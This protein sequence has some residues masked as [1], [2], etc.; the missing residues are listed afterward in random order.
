MQ[1]KFLE[2]LGLEK[3]TIDKIMDEHGKSVNREK[4]KAEDYK[5]QLDNAKNTLKGFDGVDVNDLKNQISTLTT[6]LAN[7]EADYNKKLA[8]RDFEDKLTAKAKEFKARDLKSIK[9]FLDLDGLKSSK[10]QDDDIK[11]AFEAIKKDNAYLFEDETAPKVISYTK[12]ADPSTDDE[13]TKANNA[14]RSLFGKGN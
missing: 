5:T 11:N 6:N 3:E 1:R 12:G 9:P 4:Q 14:L 2:D 8:D 13:K 7:A 10:N